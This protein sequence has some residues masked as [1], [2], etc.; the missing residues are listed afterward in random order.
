MNVNKSPPSKLYHLS[1]KKKSLTMKKTLKHI[2]IL[3]F[4]SIIIESCKKDDIDF[5]DETNLSPTG[6]FN[7]KEVVGDTAFNADTI[8]RD[9]Y[10][11]FQATDKYENVTWQIGNDPTLITQ[12]EFTLSF[13]NSLG[14]IPIE[15][16]GY[17]KSTATCSSSEN[18]IYASNKNL[19]QSPLIGS[20]K[21]YFTDTPSDTFTTRL[22]YFDSTKYDVSITGSKNF[23][24][25]SNMPKGF[26]STLPLPY[27]ELKNGFR[28][29]MGYKSFVFDYDS[30]NEGKSW[31]SNDTL[32][33]NYGNNFTGRKKFI[34]KKI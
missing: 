5:C 16:K 15:F 29:E 6:K 31:L 3:I 1:I 22:E 17:K 13:I 9:N 18:S 28:I 26:R 12:T 19:T 21:G 4:A 34:G 30:Y 27:P 24:W 23:Y 33:I 20:Y 14:T 7:F 11:E 10:V 32:F 8:F 25:F 2:V